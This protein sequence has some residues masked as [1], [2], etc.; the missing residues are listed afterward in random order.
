MQT[1]SPISAISSERSEAASASAARSADSACSARVSRPINPPSSFAR[2]P[3]SFALANARPASTP[4]S[5][6]RVITGS[7]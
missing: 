1:A 4:A 7:A 6:V 5:R 3:P 2:A